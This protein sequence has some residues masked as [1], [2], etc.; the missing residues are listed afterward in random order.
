MSE[1]NAQRRTMEIILVALTFGL[2]LFEQVCL[3][4][5]HVVEKFYYQIEPVRVFFESLPEFF[6]GWIIKERNVLIE[7]W[8]NQFVAQFLEMGYR[9]QVSAN[10]RLELAKHGQSFDVEQLDPA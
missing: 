3:S 10:C 6:G 5:F 4:F 8:H 9:T 2:N 1:R 7:I